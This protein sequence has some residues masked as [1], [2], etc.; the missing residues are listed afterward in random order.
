MTVKIR[1]KKLDAATFHSLFDERKLQ[2][3]ETAEP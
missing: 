3:L 2:L 1:K